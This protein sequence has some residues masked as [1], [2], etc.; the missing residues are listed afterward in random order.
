MAQIDMKNDELLHLVLSKLSIVGKPDAHG[1]QTAFCSF[2]QDRHRPNLSIHPEKGYRCFV[3]DAK[4]SIRD[5]AERLGIITTKAREVTMEK[6]AETEA[7]ATDLLHPTD[8]GLCQ[9]GKAVPEN[10]DEVSGDV[11]LLE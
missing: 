7:G 2:H 10:Q 11:G 5:L 8:C 9:Q 3:C 6:T 1:N 4:G